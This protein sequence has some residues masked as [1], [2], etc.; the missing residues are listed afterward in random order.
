VP[1]FFIAISLICAIGAQNAFIIR[2][3][4]T[5]QHV[6]MMVLIGFASDTAMILL[7]IGGLGA[8]IESQPW[9]LEFI[10]WFGA[11]YLTWFG[12][13]SLRAAFKGESLDASGGKLLSKKQ[14]ALSL[15]GFTFLNPHFYLDTVILIGSIGNT[16]G[17]NRWFFAIG[18]SF[19]SLVWFASIAY[20]ARAASRFMSRPIVWRI[21]DAVIAAIM[22]ALAI[23]LVFYRFA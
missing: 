6:L 12:I 16:F 5:R 21:L 2:Q 23:G 8:L 15:L 17:D 4:L 11:A 9:L 10:R 18:A 19:A 20:G 14:V 3:S 22:F 1:G 13:S 7:G